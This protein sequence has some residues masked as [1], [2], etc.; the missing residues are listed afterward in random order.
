VLIVL[1][2]LFIYYTS[3][4]LVEMGQTCIRVDDPGPAKNVLE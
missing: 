1:K 4:W 3:S 2:V